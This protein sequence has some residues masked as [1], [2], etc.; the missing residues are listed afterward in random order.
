MR[1]KDSVVTL[2]KGEIRNGYYKGQIS[3]HFFHITLKFCTER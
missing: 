3:L 1:V 2:W